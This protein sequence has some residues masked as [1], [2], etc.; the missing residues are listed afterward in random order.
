MNDSNNG[1]LVFLDRDL[2]APQPALKKALQLAHASA[3]PLTVAVNADSPALRRAVGADPQRREAAA[4]DLRGA[5]QRRIDALA[6]GAALAS[7]INLGK[8]METGLRE[9]VIECR[10]ALIV[11]HTSEEGTLKRHLFTPRDWVLIRRAPCAVLCVHSRPW[12][13]IPKMTVAVEPEENEHGLDTT[14][15]Q[16]ARRWGEPLHADLDVVHVLEHPDETL[17]LVA[18]E[19][20]PEYAASAANLYDY[21]R[22]ALDLFARRHQV[23]RE[24]VHLLEG[25]ISTTLVDYCEEHGSDL[26][27][28][29]TVRRNTFERLLLGATAEALL[30]RASNDILVVK[31]DGF[32]SDWAS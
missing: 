12:S 16:T 24:R 32:E 7:R 14:V 17:M 18:G 15:M 5:W 29:G 27:V 13:T 28:V 11:V 1:I 3:L 21:H 25:P 23:P 9:A 30:T 22:K 20:L 26:L 6:D 4:R 2:N 10:P 31:P 8:D 19:A